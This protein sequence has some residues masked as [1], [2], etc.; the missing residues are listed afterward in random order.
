MCTAEEKHH[1]LS[2]K[3]E[4]DGHLQ[5]I[6]ELLYD[7]SK[8]VVALSSGHTEGAYIKSMQVSMYSVASM[9]S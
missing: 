8:P 3:R 5:S 4:D 9:C 6:G 7:S 2:G 1:Y